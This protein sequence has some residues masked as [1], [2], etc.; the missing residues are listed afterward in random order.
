MYE[1]LESVEIFIDKGGVVLYAILFLTFILW[2]MLM[3]RFIYISFIAKNLKKNLIDDSKLYKNIENWQVLKIREYSINK[4]TLSLRDS[5]RIIKSLII[6]APF[7]GLLGTVSG[8]IE[9]FDVMAMT[10]SSDAKSMANG[11]GMATIPTLAGMVISISGV[12]FV[13]LYENKVKLECQSLRES[14]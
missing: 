5:M 4:Y 9:I 8:M 14:L 12:F 1:I 13:S 2:M 6:I 11:V 3:E 7:L 10:G